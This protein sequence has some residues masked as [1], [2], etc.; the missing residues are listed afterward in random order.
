MWAGVLHHVTGEHVW[1]LDACQH[2][3]L[4][5]DKEKDWIA[6]TAGLGIGHGGH[7]PG[8][9]KPFI[10]FFIHAK[11]ASNVAGHVNFNAGHINVNSS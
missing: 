3:P 1:A 9:L 11:L 6:R 5:E 7:M 2:G 4:V 10:Y 8:G